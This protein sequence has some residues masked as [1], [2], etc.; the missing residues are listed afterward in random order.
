[1]REMVIS[2]YTMADDEIMT[3]EVDIRKQRDVDVDVGKVW[4]QYEVIANELEYPFLSKEYMTKMFDYFLETLMCKRPT[5]TAV[6]ASSEC[7]NGGDGNQSS[8]GNILTCEL[9][10]DIYVDPVTLLCGHSFCRKCLKKREEELF[11]ELCVKCDKRKTRRSRW[12]NFFKHSS[13]ERFCPNVIVNTLV[14]ESFGDEL[15][16]IRLRLEGNE[17]YARSDLQKAE[18]KYKS[19][20]EISESII[21]LL[22]CHW[23]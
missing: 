18:E 1:M 13:F 22:F 4:H 12:S 19:A 11:I 7:N 20:I 14:K 15:K 8:I 6:A 10:C 9:C 17:H 5:P 3:D 2:A 23:F 21:S 16:A